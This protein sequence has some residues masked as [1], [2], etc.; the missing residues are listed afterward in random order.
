MY[1]NKEVDNILESI[2]KTLNIDDRISKYKDLEEKFNE[3]IPAILIYS[4][5]YL[6]ITSGR[7][8]NISFEGITVPSDRFASVYTWST[9]TDK[10]W[11]IFTK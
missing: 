1:N 7:L 2:Q 4:P 6:Y 9:D 5:T 8:N 11:K 3:N 10:V